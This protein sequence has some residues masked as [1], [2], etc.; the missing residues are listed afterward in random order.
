MPRYSPKVSFRN[1]PHLFVGGSTFTLIDGIY[2]GSSFL[3]SLNIS[4]GISYFLKNRIT[5]KEVLNCIES[6]K[7]YK[8][9]VLNYGY[10]DTLFETR[11][12]FNAFKYIENNQQSKLLKLVLI[13][14]F[15]SIPNTSLRIFKANT[16]KILQAIPA[17]SNIILVL[18]IPSSGN[19]LR[20]FHRNRYRKFLKAM[21]SKYDLSNCKILDLS[22]YNKSFRSIDNH[23]LNAKGA[24]LLKKM[25][26]DEL[27]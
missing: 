6:N 7:S 5:S 22:I 24:K 13:C 18:N 8:V 16:N 25:L 1:T 12:V 10:G 17:V 21:V 11:K 19:V 20:N 9:Y 14:L 3:E 23:H 4:N 27:F 15:A 26:E 2:V